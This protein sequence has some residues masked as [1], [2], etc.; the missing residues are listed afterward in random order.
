MH[1]PVDING[2]HVTNLNKIGTKTE[3]T[4]IHSIY[5]SL[6]EGKHT[7][8]E[9]CLLLCF[10]KKLQSNNHNNVATLSMCPMQQATVTIHKEHYIFHLIRP[11]FII[12]IYQTLHVS[13]KPITSGVCLY[14]NLKFKAKI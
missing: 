2:F 8:K 6:R 10:P 9:Q 7:C 5:N 12:I 1:L 11:V 3:G 13:I 14:K 4:R